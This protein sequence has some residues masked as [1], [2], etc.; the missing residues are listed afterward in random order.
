MDHDGWNDG[1]GSDRDQTEGC[2]EQRRV[3]KPDK[4][5]VNQSEKERG[6]RDANPHGK[7]LVEAAQHEATEGQLLCQRCAEGLCDQRGNQ[8]SLIDEAGIRRIACH[9]G[10]GKEVEHGIYEKH[11]SY[12]D[13]EQNGQELR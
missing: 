10:F 5:A 7:S 9:P 3:Y 12:Q 1:A 8:G 4:V 2:T 13:Q 6:D 11:E